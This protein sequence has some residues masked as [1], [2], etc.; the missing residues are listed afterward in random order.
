MDRN[1]RALRIKAVQPS[2]VAEKLRRQLQGDLDNIVLMA[3]RREAP[4]RYAS[5]DGLSEDIDRYLASQP[6]MARPDTRAY[7]AAKFVVRNKGLVAMGTVLFLMVAAG[8]SATVW[9]AHIARKQRDLARLEQNKAARI[10]AFLQEM[11]GYSAVT[12]GTPVS[13]QYLL[14]LEGEAFVS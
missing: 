1:R 13:E 14:D 3:M 8:V 7:R 10:S 4:R 5:A 11:V 12:P 6:V 2:V 9:E